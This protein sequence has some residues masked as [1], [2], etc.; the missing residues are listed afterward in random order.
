[1]DCVGRRSTHVLLCYFK[2]IRNHCHGWDSIVWHGIFIGILGCC[3]VTNTFENWLLLL[4]HFH[5]ADYSF[6][7]QFLQLHNFHSW[8]ISTKSFLCQLLHLLQLSFTRPGENTSSPT[9]C[10][11]RISSVFQVVLTALCCPWQF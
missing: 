7:L 11:F 5:F 4:I 2:L 1:M 8:I 6:L 3:V 10:V 9:L